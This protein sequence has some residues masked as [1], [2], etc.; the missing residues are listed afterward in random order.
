MNLKPGAL[1]KVT[2]MKPDNVTVQ[3]LHTTD[4]HGAAAPVTRKYEVEGEK[5][6]KQ[7]GGT[8]FLAEAVEEYRDHFSRTL[9]VDT[10]DSVS[11]QVSTDLDE[12]RSMVKVMNEVGYD[13]TITGNHGFDFGP[14]ALRGRIQSANYPVLATNLTNSDGSPLKNT[15]SS[16]V[17]DLNGVKVGLVGLLTDKIPYLV[18]EENRA[19]FEVADVQESLADE[20]PKLKEQGAEMIVVL[21]HQDDELDEALAARFPDEGMIILGGHSHVEMTEPK[22][23]A[24]NFLY[25]SGSQ[26]AALGQVL[27]SFDRNNHK[28]NGVTADAIPMDHW[29]FL[30]D[31]KVEKMVEGLQ[32]IADEKMGEVVLDLKEPLTRSA[33]E[34]SNLGNLFTDAMRKHFK[35][36]VAL[37]NTDGLRVDVESGPV[38]KGDLHAIRPFPGDEAV[39]GKMKGEHLLAA[40]QHS[41][42]HRDTDGKSPFLQVSGVSFQYDENSVSDVLVGGQPL[43]S[44]K[45][46]SVVLNSY[47]TEGKLGYESFNKGQWEN[48]GLGF[49]ELMTSYLGKT[50]LNQLDPAGTRIKDKTK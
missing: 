39:P 2:R 11:G 48:A 15:S 45:M 14:D 50:D 16:K 25:K 46:Y 3:L 21:S 17:C 5:F 20:L 7:M 28:V 49:L 23:V 37:V 1:G 12:G 47:L 31:P 30:P 26:G 9:V 24:G 8:A 19:G 6:N 32:V 22:K 40:L 36:D 4:M 43:D 34:D 27:V 35:T 44:E 29:R 38:T 13:A 33:S 42:T 18:T 41:V 10:G